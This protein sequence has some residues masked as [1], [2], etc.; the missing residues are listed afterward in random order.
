[1]GEVTTVGKVKPHETIVSVHEGGVDV[2]VGWSAGESYHHGMDGLDI[3]CRTQGISRYRD[4]GERE[5][6]RVHTLYVDTPFLPIQTKSL[7]GSLL[8]KSFG[9]IYEF[10]SAV[11]TCAGIT[12]RVLVWRNKSAVSTWHR[13]VVWACLL[14]MTL[15]RASSTAWE[16]KF[17][18]GMRLMKCFCL[19][20][21]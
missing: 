12:F 10:V 2:E 8:A 9:L 21:S 7:E 18:E 3:G 1:M 20:F 15:P 14:C 6:E 4:R 16:V 13:G 11:V 19:F 17:S 5:R